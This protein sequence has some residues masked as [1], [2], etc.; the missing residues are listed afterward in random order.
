M[1]HTSET[2]NSIIVQIPDQE[3]VFAPLDVNWK[4]MFPYE[5]VLFNA[6]SASKEDSP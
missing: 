6:E 3:W 2:H 5:S 1:H 4:I